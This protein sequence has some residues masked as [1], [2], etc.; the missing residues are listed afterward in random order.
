MI[1]D[2]SFPRPPKMGLKA[3]NEQK[4]LVSGIREPLILL[5]SQ[6]FHK[7]C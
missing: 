4:L 2:P 6:N 5:S 1:I 7:I 3:Q